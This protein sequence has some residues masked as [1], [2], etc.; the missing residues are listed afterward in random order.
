MPVERLDTGVEG[1][2]LGDGGP[3]VAVGLDAGQAGRGG[4]GV[5]GERGL[6]GDDGADRQGCLDRVRGVGGDDDGA[7]DFLAAGGG[8]GGFGLEGRE[9]VGELFQHEGE[10]RGGGEVGLGFGGG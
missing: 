6:V 8:C 2:V 7:G 3:G 5:A 9:R 10:D 1:A 4:E